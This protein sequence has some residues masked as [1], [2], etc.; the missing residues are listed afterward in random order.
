MDLARLRFQKRHWDNPELLIEDI[1][2]K[3]LLSV[4][5]VLRHATP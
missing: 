1:H 4:P 3:Q 5:L 2:L